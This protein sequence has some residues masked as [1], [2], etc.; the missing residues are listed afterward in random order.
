MAAARAEACS[1]SS[2]DSGWTRPRWMRMAALSVITVPSGR[3][4]VG[5]CRS[6]FTRSS[7]AMSL[8]LSHEAAAT[9]RYGCAHSSS[10][11]STA[12]DPE[13]LIPNSVY[14]GAMLAM[15]PGLPSLDR[16]QDESPAR[17]ALRAP[18]LLALVELL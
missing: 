12:A 15:L 9:S 17:Q 10:A 18:D 7:C 5:I 6:G 16:R 8:L 11:H 2:P 4:S 14:I 3:T 1:G 13:P